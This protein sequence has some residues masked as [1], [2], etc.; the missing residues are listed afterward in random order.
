MA[1]TL[2]VSHEPAVL[3]VSSAVG[4]GTSNS[5]LAAGLPGTFSLPP[6]PVV[7]VPPLPFLPPVPPLEEAVSCFLPSP[8]EDEA[9]QMPPA[10]ISAIA[11]TAATTMNSVVFFRPPPPGPPCG[12]IGMVGGWPG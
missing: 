1:Y 10:T 2:L 9:Y 7:P 3:T 11:T 8:P 12:C 4:S 6:P 5:T